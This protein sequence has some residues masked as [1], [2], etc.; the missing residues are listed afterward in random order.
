VARRLAHHISRPGLRPAA[1]RLRGHGFVQGAAT[2][3]RIRAISCTRGGEELA[4]TLMPLGE[5]HKTRCASARAPAAG[6]CSTSPTARHLLIEERRFASSARFLPRTPAHRKPPPE[7]GSGPTRDCFHTL[8]QR[9]AWGW[10]TARPPRAALDVA[11]KDAGASLIVVQ[12]HDH[13]LLSSSALTTGA[14]MARS[15]AARRPLQCEGALP[16]GRSAGAARARRRHRNAWCSSK[17]QRA[18]TPGQYAVAY[19]GERCLGGAASK[20]SRR[21]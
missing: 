7:S 20:T 13:P 8:G 9:A 16:P 6:R 12:G 15:P 19:E 21:R 4:R 18:V 14:C 10:R 5:L 3:R 11:A 1:G 2:A 17:P